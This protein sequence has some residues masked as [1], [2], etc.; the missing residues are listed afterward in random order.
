[1]N[2]GVEVYHEF[3][4]PP[5]ADYESPESMIESLTPVEQPRVYAQQPSNNPPNDEHWIFGVCSK[6]PQPEKVFDAYGLL[7][8]MGYETTLQEVDMHYPELITRVANM[9][10]NSSQHNFA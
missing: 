1:M 6:S 2:T 7:E 3:G 9:V 4:D 5:L 10:I 8:P